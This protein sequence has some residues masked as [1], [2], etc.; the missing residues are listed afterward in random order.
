[1]KFV[2]DTCSIFV[3]IFFFANYSVKDFPRFTSAGLRLFEFMPITFI[4][5]I[6]KTFFLNNLCSFCSDFL[7]KMTFF[8]EILS[9]SYVSIVRSVNNQSL[10]DHYY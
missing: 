4:F 1:M 2:Y 10:L 6:R 3:P 9:T 5:S 8:L 7:L